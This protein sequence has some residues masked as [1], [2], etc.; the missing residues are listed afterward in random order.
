M[1]NAG[2]TPANVQLR[3][4]GAGGVVSSAPVVPP[5]RQSIL[6]DI[7]GGLGVSDSGAIQIVSDQP[8]RVT[9]RTYNQVSGTASCYAGGTQGQDY[10]ALV[11]TDGLGAS[12]SAY[13]AGLT[14]C[15]AYRCNIGLV[16][17]GTD[18]A[19]VLVELFNYVGGK[20]TDYTVSLSAGQWSQATQPFLNCAGQS[21]MER[22]YAKVTVKTGS[23]VFA[24]ASVV[25]NITN[26]PT[27]VAMQ[28]A[29]PAQ[30]MSAG[31]GSLV[32]WLPVAS[33]N[34]GKNHSQW[35]SDLGML[36]AG[37]TAANVEIRFF[38]SGGAATTTTA[39]SPRTQALVVDCVGALGGSGS[40]AIEVLSDQPLHVTGRTYNLVAPDA[41]CDPEG[42]QGQDYP[43]LASA[44]GLAEGEA[45]YLAGLTENVAYRCNIG[46]VNTGPGP[47]SV[48]VELLDGAGAALADYSVMLPSGQWSQAT[49]PFLS[50]ANQTA[51]D[52]GYARVTVLAGS[53]VFA[54]ASVIDNI[55]NDP[56]TIAMR[57]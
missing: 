12:E 38:G 41:D 34:P 3:F 36:N 7:V 9:A 42:T 13:L 18:V 52:C 16:N 23:G 29:D 2:A 27:T 31:P 26:D 22:G 14:E 10:P 49:Q 43:P 5:G 25:D 54:F 47:A 4:Y 11:A 28:V 53:G 19:T 15:A 50:Y 57:R 35:R 40:G 1:L 46:L 51:M 33:H 39:V 24:F 55:T 21:A 44:D 20:F 48:R 8:L 56:T 6:A 30:E 17:T 37:A 32:T 45:A